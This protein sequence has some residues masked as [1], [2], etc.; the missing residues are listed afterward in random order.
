MIILLITT[1]P[2]RVYDELHKIHHIV[3]Y[4]IDCKHINRL[5]LESRIETIIKNKDLTF[6]LTY[7]C[8]YI[9]PNNIFN[10]PKNGSYNIH[11]S[12]L[13]LYAGLNPWKA[14]FANHET[15]NGVTL[16]RITD[17]V[18]QGEVLFQKKYA[19]TPTDNILTARDKADIIAAEFALKLI[20]SSV[21]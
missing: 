6:I 19:I 12:L 5:L 9:L 15:V 11:P 7:R 4:V 3:L 10:M 1:L 17:K 21:N 8:P 13:P 18:D 16:H 2:N 20:S 14:I